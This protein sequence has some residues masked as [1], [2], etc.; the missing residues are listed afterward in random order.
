MREQK[1]PRGQLHQRWPRRLKIDEI[2]GGKYQLQAGGGGADQ[3]R[4]RKLVK[5]FRAEMLGTASSNVIMKRYKSTRPSRRDND[6]IRG[7][8]RRQRRRTHQKRG[9]RTKGETNS[10]IAE[11][12]AR[13]KSMGADESGRTYTTKTA[14]Y[15]PAN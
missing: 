5:A 4:N 10:S 11:S 2:R 15:E 14:C 1:N 12:S 9:A 8:G 3:T 7:G 6:R 13:F